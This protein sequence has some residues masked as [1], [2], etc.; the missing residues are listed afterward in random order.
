MPWGFSDASFAFGPAPVAPWPPVGLSLYRTARAA[1]SCAAF[2]GRRPPATGSS[3]PFFGT[4]QLLELSPSAARFTGR[5]D[6]TTTPT[7][8]ARLSA[9]AFPKFGWVGAWAGRWGSQYDG[10]LIKCFCDEDPGLSCACFLR[11]I[12]SIS[13]HFHPSEAL[14]FLRA[15]FLLMSFARTI[16]DDCPSFSK[17]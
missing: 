3:C 10:N 4:R 2:F 7:A 16:K 12:G 8:A 9:R 5:A 14:K 6:R 17:L 13:L 15:W 1:A 11:L